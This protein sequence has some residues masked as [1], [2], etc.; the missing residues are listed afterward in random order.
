MR[1]YGKTT[2]PLFSVIITQETIPLTRENSDKFH[3]FSF[4]RQ[5]WQFRLIVAPEIIPSF[6]TLSFLGLTRVL[7]QNTYA[8]KLHIEPW[9]SL[10]K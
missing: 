10:A 5:F 3:S 9:W 1:T 7:F 8:K 2:G 4:R 6:F